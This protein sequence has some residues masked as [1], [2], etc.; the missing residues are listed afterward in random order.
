MAGNANWVGG[1]N[2]ILRRRGSSGRAGGAHS[3]GAMSAG[4]KRTIATIERN[5]AASYKAKRKGR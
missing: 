1:P 5:L 3:G 4:R 2:F